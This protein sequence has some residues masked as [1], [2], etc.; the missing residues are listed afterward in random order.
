M[1]AEIHLHPYVKYGFHWADFH[2]THMLRKF[3]YR[4]CVSNFKENRRINV[5]SVCLFNFY[6]RMHFYVIKILY[7]QLLM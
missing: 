4:I 1:R 5:K 2:G 7:K 6:Q 3:L